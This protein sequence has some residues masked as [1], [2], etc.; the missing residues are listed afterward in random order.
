MVQLKSKNDKSKQM[1]RVRRE[2]T[3]PE[4]RLR[5]IAH[6]MGLRFRLHR[7]DLPGTPDLFFPRYR[8]AIFVHGCFWHQHPNCKRA[9]M[10]KTRSEFW[11]D[12][13]GRNR[14]RDERVQQELRELGWQPEVFWECQLKDER[15]VRTRLREIF[16]LVK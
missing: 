7:R 6:K 13:L 2:N 12:K 9:A 10:P 5:S 4:L 16:Q 14:N 8:I 15:Q 1:A 11:R 3:E